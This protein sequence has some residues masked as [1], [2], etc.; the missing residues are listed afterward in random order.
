MS[1]IESRAHID[2]VLICEANRTITGEPR[3]LIYES[4]LGSLPNNEVE[5]V[6]Y[7][8]LDISSDARAYDGTDVPL[9]H[10]EQ[11]IRD[12]FRRY[13][14][15]QP[16]DVVI[17]LDADEVIH[18][19]HYD[20]ILSRL[21]TKRNAPKSF[22]LR[23]HMFAYYANYWWTNKK[24]RAAVACQAGYFMSQDVASW[25]DDGRK[26]Y[27]PVGSHFAWVMT[28]D[29][30]RKKILRYAHRP[31]LEHLAN[32]ELLSR[33]VEDRRYIFDESAKFHIKEL[34]EFRPG[35]QPSSLRNLAPEYPE[36]FSL[37]WEGSKEDQSRKP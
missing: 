2:E 18:Q 9:H 16:E 3:E 11:L 29:E 36:L 33:A 21:M 14:T 15:V 10:N 23:L 27:R 32:V 24:W 31:D 6:R 1:L 4:I 35:V 20:W 26:T 13:V 25:R 28:T 30:M 8:P 37:A 34:T 7:V 5:R 19:E 22:Q 12:A 17:A